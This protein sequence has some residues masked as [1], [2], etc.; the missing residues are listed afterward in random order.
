MTNEEVL[1]RVKVWFSVFETE[2][3]SAYSP[4]DEAA[5]K[6][7]TQILEGPRTIGYYAPYIPRIDWRKTGLALKRIESIVR[8]RN[9]EERLREAARIARVLFG[10][11]GL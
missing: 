5:L 7:V 8:N 2:S 9:C 1:K 11:G 3:P 10:R 4:E 6:R